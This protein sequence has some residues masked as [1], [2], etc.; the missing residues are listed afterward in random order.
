M[1]KRIFRCP[2]CSK[3]STGGAGLASHIRSAHPNPPA[4]SKEKPAVKPT[5]K[6]PVAAPVTGSVSATPR[7]VAA[8]SPAEKT[9][10]APSAGDLL[11]KAFAQLS[12]WS[13]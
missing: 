2:Y 1:P 12:A 4:S 13:V 10:G 3:K 8:P 6:T 9:K 5:P 11:A 7:K